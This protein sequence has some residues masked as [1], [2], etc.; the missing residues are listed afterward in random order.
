MTSGSLSPIE[1]RRLA[2]TI[3]IPCH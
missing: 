3:Q 2:L 1:K